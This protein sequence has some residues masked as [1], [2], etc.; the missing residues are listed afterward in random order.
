MPTLWTFSFNSPCNFVDAEYIFEFEGVKYRL[1]RG[2]E[3]E[4]DKLLT[5]SDDSSQKGTDECFER[6]MR[7]L[8]YLSWDLPSGIQFLGGT[9]YGMKENIKL[10]NAY[11]V[12]FRRRNLRYILTPGF[13]EIPDVKNDTQKFALSLWNEA[14][15]SASPFLAF[16]NY[17]KIIELIPQGVKSKGSAKS[18]AIKWING[19]PINRINGLS[20]LKKILTTRR[21]KKTIGD[22]LYGECRNAIAHVTRKPT[23]KP[24]NVESLKQISKPKEVMRAIAK[25]YIEKELKLEYST[26]LKI[27]KTKKRTNALKFLR[28]IKKNE[29]TQRKESISFIRRMKKPF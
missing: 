26:P 24:S 16:I 23:L 20:E 22:Y 6:T 28:E 5:I 2:T 11:A 13:T 14:K 29:K 19:L 15:V 3:D 17:W 25:Y 21:T 10:E 9:G 27:I 4:S 12:G 8:D 7:L 1:I 18:R